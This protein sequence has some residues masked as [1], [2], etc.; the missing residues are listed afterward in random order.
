M[1]D[2]KILNNKILAIEIELILLKF[3]LKG[4]TV[5]ETRKEIIKIF[6]EQ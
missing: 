1:N 5:E 3:A 6:K 4:L 2:I